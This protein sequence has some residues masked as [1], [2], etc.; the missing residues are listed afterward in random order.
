[1]T[2]LIVLLVVAALFAGWYLTLPEPVDALPARPAGLA[3]P[4]RGAIHVHTNRSDGTGSV[5]QVAA[6]AARAG[7]KFVIFT[8]HGDGT[9]LPNP[10]AYHDGVLCIEAV[11]ISTENGH[12]VAIALGQSP[13]RLGGEA[14]DVVDDVSRM[15]GTSIAAHP[16]SAKPDLRWTNWAAPIDGLEWLN[17][18]SEWRDEAAPTLARLLWTYPLRKPQALA[19]LLDRPQEAM[20]RWD[21][22]TS[23]RRVVAVAAADAHARVGLRTVGEPFDNGL[24]LRVPDYESVFRTFS[25]GVTDVAL[26]GDAIVDS[27]TVLEAVR[28]G[29]AYSTIDALGGPAAF[30]FTARSGEVTA[31]MGSPLPLTGAAS[32]HVVA[33]A[34]AGARIALLRGGTEI[35]AADGSTLEHTDSQPGVYRVEITLPGAPGSPPVPWLVSNPIY[36]GR[37]ATDLPPPSA[38]WRAADFAVQYAD[39]P[40]D[41]WRVE[42]SAQ[43]LGAIDRL[44]AV[45]GDEIGFRWGLGG[46]RADSPFAAMVMPAGGMIAGYDGLIFNARAPRPMRVSVQ[47]RA[48]GGGSGQRWQRSVYI[49]ENPRELSVRFDDMRPTGDTSQPRPALGTVESV[50]FVIDSVNANTGTNGQFIIDNV[51]YAR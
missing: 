51:R 5:A 32:F 49:D 38:V 13:Y 17:G 6:A 10:P 21:D 44:P 45:K 25:I 28:Q 15:G 31:A 14:R 35:A 24:S 41:G 46:T 4:I 43:S 23:R 9:A 8:D 34:P 42:T 22:L 2:R 1:V 29:Q 48:P 27:G 3:P 11:E 20:R 16:A 33:Q 26:S 37:S 50:L 47:L 19:L 39:G 12:L 30:A 36:A 18:D 40:I 7:L